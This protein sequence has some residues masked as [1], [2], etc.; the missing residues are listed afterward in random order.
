MSVEDNQRPFLYQRLYDHVL[1]EIRAGRLSMGDRVP[2]E[3]EL[4]QLFGVSRITSKKALQTL[5]RDGVVER[6]IGKGS[7]VAAQLPALE[8]LSSA[9]RRLALGELVV[10]ASGL[11]C[12]RS[13]RRSRSVSWKESR[14]EQRSSG[15]TSSSADPTVAR[16]WRS[17]SSTPL[18]N[19]ELVDGLIVF[20]V[21]GEY[22]NRSLL[23]L[24]LDRVPPVLADR[25]LNGIAACAVTT[26]HHAAALELTGTLL[27]M[28]HEHLAFISA[29]V[30]NTTSLEDRIEGFRGAFAHRG[31]SDNTHHV[32]T[33]L[34]STP[35]MPSVSGDTDADRKG[36]AQLLDEHRRSRRSLPPNTSLQCLCM[37]CSRAWAGSMVA[38]SRA[39]TCPTCRSRRTTSY[40]SG[41][42]SVRWDG[43]PSTSLSRKWR[44]TP[45]LPSRSS[46]T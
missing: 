4:A 39:S 22:H 37:R 10:R 8:S 12:R 3:M 11:C 33:T 27:A 31:R 42:T 1:D 38:R 20:A 18:M 17:R 25:A 13:R 14:R 24:V 36:I 5:N 15:S 21:N 7:F 29:P 44:T 32:L 35:N 19:S 46:L 28:G 43:S 9:E 34:R 16:T 6:I 41:R 45:Y 40:T 2:S 23:R 30:N 26:D